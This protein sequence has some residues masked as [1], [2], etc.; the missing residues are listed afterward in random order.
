MD[1]S[2]YRRDIYTA[3]R[4]ICEK[5]SDNTLFYYSGDKI[6]YNETFSLVN[7]RSAFLIK[8]GF[9]KDD[10]IGILSG[11]SP[12][13]CITFLAITAIGAVALPLDTSF[14]SDQYESMVKSAGAKAVFVSDEFSD[15]IRSIPCMEISKN[16]CI[17]DEKFFTPIQIPYNNIAALLFTSGTTGS[18]KIVQL[19]HMNILHIAYVCTD[20]EE[21]TA[22][23][24]TLAIL[25]LF[26]VYAF[27]STFMA[28]LVTGSSIVMQNSL[29]GPDIMKSLADFPVTIFPAAPLMWELFFNAIANRAKA[30]SMLKYRIFMFFA[31]NARVL[32]LFGLGF[33]VKK[34][35]TPVHDVF[36][37]S[38]RFFISGGAPMKREYFNYYKNMGFNIME[39]YGLSET[40]G[41]IAIPYYK[42]A[43]AGSV[44][45]PIAGNEVIIKHINEDRIGEICF[46]GDAVMPGYFKN[47]EATGSAFDENGY[48]RTGDLGRLDRKGNI[49]ITGRMKNVIVLD[50][51]KKVYPE[52]L[53][54]YFRESEMIAE[55]AVFEK[56]T[57]NRTG[58][59]AVIVPSVKSHESYSIIRSEIEILNKNLPD[60]KKIK[61]FAVSFDEL[62]KNSTKKILYR[63]INTLL[64]QGVYQVNDTGAPVLRDLFRPGTI[65]EEHTANLL[66][67]LLKTDLLFANQTLADFNIDSL[68]TVDLMVRLE[69]RLDIVINIKEFVKKQTITDIITYLMSLEKT[70]GE[71]IEERILRGKIETKPH[72]FFNPMHHVAIGI[73]GGLSRLFWKIKVFND[74]N[75]VLNNK[76][77]VANHQSY[78]DMVWISYFIPSRYRKNVYATAKKKLSFLRFVFPIFP[79]IFVDDSNS[80][81]VL[82]AS[83]DFL[84]QGK[85]LIIFPEGTRSEDGKIQQF[86]SGAAYLAKNLNIK[87]IP[88]SVNGAHGIWPKQQKFPTFLT[89]LKGTVTVGK[90]ID[91]SAYDSVESLNTALEAAVISGMS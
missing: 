12:E 23:D 26:H 68:G 4:D 57:N 29:K 76:I 91:P 85:T 61:Q 81:E 66:K 37:K 44:G 41:P 11:S 69:Q 54:F 31:N 9:A 5:H 82:K 72:L 3:T 51:G 74:E 36:G 19:S 20:L 84:R 50:S 6:S 39:G 86:K 17:D 48:F 1:T 55:I 90:E 77:I 32:R 38:H 58:V 7:K 73:L 71:P 16:A 34:I 28:P 89:S 67:E 22:E 70:G 83:A 65:E 87:V 2:L 75:L 46:K 56:V 63:E 53:E 59:F 24:V 13:W 64:D 15:K 60:Y 43:I 40:T 14:Q 8:N 33:I 78:L 35:F 18:P 52:E 62:P 80:I 25:P 30:Q 79:V 49:Y 45:A 27:E 42:S 88:V 21:Y 10:I 47:D